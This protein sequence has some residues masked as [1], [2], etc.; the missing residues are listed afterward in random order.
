MGLYGKTALGGVLFMRPLIT[1]E[2]HGFKMTHACNID[3]IRSLQIYAYASNLIFFN[4]FNFFIRL[5]DCRASIAQANF[6]LNFFFCFC[7][8]PT[9]SIFFPP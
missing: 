7:F 3:D 2:A 6:F 1:V 9:P 5:W 4:T 8:P